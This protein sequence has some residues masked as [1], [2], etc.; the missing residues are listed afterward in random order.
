VLETHPPDVIIADAKLLPSIL[1][2][3]YDS[4]EHGHHKIVVL[5]EPEPAHLAMVASQVKIYRWHDLER[6]G[7]KIDKIISQPPSQFISLRF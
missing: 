3:I 2:L 4:N 1:E 7:T 5:G 6:E